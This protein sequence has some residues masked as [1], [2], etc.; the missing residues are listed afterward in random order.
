MT[1][2]FLLLF[3]PIILYIGVQ[4]KSTKI[5][6]KLHSD[7]V[8]A[9][10]DEGLS[11]VRVQM[12]GRDLQL[13]G[14]EE[15]L[16]QAY[17]VAEA[18]SGVKLP[19]EL[20]E[21]RSKGKLKQVFE[22]QE[23]NLGVTLSGQVLHPEVTRWPEKRVVGEYFLSEASRPLA[24]YDIVKGGL[25]ESFLQN[26]RND[27]SLKVS[28]HDKKY[29]QKEKLYPPV[30]E[31]LNRYH[32]VIDRSVDDA[33][34]SRDRQTRI[35]Q[36]LHPEEV[37][38]PMVKESLSPT[39]QFEN[40]IVD[41][42]VIIAY[43]SQNQYIPTVQVQH[44]SYAF[45]PLKINGEAPIRFDQEVT[46]PMLVKGDEINAYLSQRKF[47]PTLQVEHPEKTFWPLKNSGEVIRFDPYNVE[48]M[49]VNKETIQAYQARQNRNSIVQV[50]HTKGLYWPIK[51]TYVESLNEITQQVFLINKVKERIEVTGVVPT[52]YIQDTLRAK[53]E[54]YVSIPEDFFE[55][56]IDEGESIPDWYNGNLPLLVPFFQW[57]E[58]GQL[59]YKNKQIIVKGIV[60]SRRAIEAFDVA[61][62]NLGN[63]FRVEN[64]LRIELE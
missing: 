24:E 47:V 29:E 57:V 27:D 50:E 1:R 41:G 28:K 17:A 52:I 33:Y 11:E 16:D 44:P 31:S 54:Q 4:N 14:P 56:A 63:Q 12:D 37:F 25:I 2:W 64:R 26:K 22:Q 15:M 21:K 23:S 10:V 59:R 45:W 32:L 30:S 18:V 49:I 60:E 6:Q 13:T 42:E 43:L 36:I 19:G 53:L 48:H 61:V 35:D 58:E 39:L 3:L 46:Q 51:N 5:E 20:L 38:W 34:Q 9:L 8:L 62:S 55:V 40:S 7:V